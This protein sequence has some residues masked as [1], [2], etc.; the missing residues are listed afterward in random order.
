VDADCDPTTEYDADADGHDVAPIGDDC[1]DTSALIAPGNPETWYDGVDQDCNP[2]TEWDQDGDGLGQPGTPH[3]YPDDCD[4]R[5][6]DTGGPTPWYRDADG[7]SYGITGNVIFACAAPA[8]FTARS[9]DCDDLR[10]D[11]S[12]DAVEV[13][14]DTDEDCDGAFDDGAGWLRFYDAD[15]DGHGDPACGE[16]R[17][18]PFNAWV[19]FDDDCDDTR[20][21]R[22][23]DEPEQCDDLDNDCNDLVDDGVGSWW[24]VDA[25]SDTYG[26][27]NSP[28]QQSCTPVPGRVLSANDCND[29]NAAFYPGA[30]D[31]CDGQDQDC[32]RTVDEDGWELVFLDADADGYGELGQGGQRACLGPGLA[33]RTGDCDDADPAKN[34]GATELCD[35]FDNNCDGRTDEGLRLDLLPDADG[36]G[37]GQ[38]G[39]AR[40][41]VCADAPRWA[42]GGGDCD[43]TNPYVRPGVPEIC[44]QVD[45][46]CDGVEDEGLRADRYLDRDDDGYGADLQPDACDAPGL[47]TRGGDCDDADPTIRPDTVDPC[48]GTDNDCDTRV[49][50]DSPY[51][52]F[53]DA[54]GDGHAA[55]FASLE[56]ACPPFEGYAP[57]NDDC[58]DTDPSLSP[59]APEFCDG[60]D[61][62]CNGQPDDDL[63]ISG[64]LDEDGDGYGATYFQDVCPEDFTLVDDGGDCDDDDRFR[65]PRQA[66]LCDGKDNDCDPVTP[67]D[68]TINDR[69]GISEVCGDW[70]YHTFG[71]SI[72]LSN[73]SPLS[74]DDAEEQCATWGYHVIWPSGFFEFASLQQ[75]LMM[76]FNRTYW[77][78]VV[79]DCPSHL[80]SGWAW[81]DRAHDVCDSLSLSEFGVFG[82][83]PLG[84]SSTA[85]TWKAIDGDP[86]AQPPVLGDGILDSFN[87]VP[88]RTSSVNYVICERD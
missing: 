64:W 7:D 39:A 54:D 58:D 21:D 32:D 48:D 9:G 88:Q 59:S 33:P 20:P 46:D 24:Y 76:H 50:E 65:A 34:P 85:L 70:R 12:P 19:A 51:A 83:N 84:R 16:L 14:G 41:S 42:V 47:V 23:P 45:N 87:Y 63:R 8:G 81:F 18:P 36:D 28:P 73:Q 13:C 60:F 25:D 67:I 75:E 27:P 6:T 82:L 11:V 35:T 71:G 66:E 26:D 77:T 3:P 62:N 5:A 49:D 31:D 15:R 61:T 10:P 30:W 56:P 1:D 55:T 69:P 79:Y 74:W 29:A 22:S 2:A 52:R 78:G 38:A 80:T 4:D 40:Q 72:Y 68:R 43:D 53:P 37:Y 44:D 57:N 86:T 17:C